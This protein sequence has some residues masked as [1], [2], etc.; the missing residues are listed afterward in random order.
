MSR[1]RGGFTLAEAVVAL[2]IVAAG[3]VAAERLLARSARTV[4][5]ERAAIRAQLTAQRLLAEARMAP[6]PT[7][8]VSGTTADGIAYE[9]RVG[10][11]EHPA[12]REVSVRIWAGD[13]P[14]ASC[15]LVEIVRVEPD[16]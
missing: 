9:R 5:A 8:L 12:L 3:V 4:A 13:A 15:E 16:A 1:P 10:P 2:A 11:S 14:G 7:G 6:L